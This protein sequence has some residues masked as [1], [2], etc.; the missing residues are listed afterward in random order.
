MTRPAEHG[1]Q[2]LGPAASPRVAPRGVAGS[3]GR[4]DSAF[5]AVGTEVEK[6]EHAARGHGT[7]TRGSR[8]LGPFGPVVLTLQIGRCRRQAG[9]PRG[10]HPP[11]FLLRC[12]PW[13]PDGAFRVYCPPRPQPLTR[14]SAS[15]VVAGAGVPSGSQLAGAPAPLHRSRAVGRGTL[16]LPSQT[17]PPPP[18]GIVGTRQAGPDQ[19]ASVCKPGGAPRDLL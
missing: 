5:V 8:H 2:G 4:W 17:P 18:P 7:P 14:V 1:G 16:H 3:R 6:L 10:M 11:W 9:E 19:A 13:T 12:I 15:P